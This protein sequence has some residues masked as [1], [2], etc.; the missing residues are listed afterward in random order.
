MLPMR[1]TVTE[2]PMKKILIVDDEKLMLFSLTAMFKDIDC[3]VMTATTG[4]EALQA[5]NRNRFD[6]C[7]LDIHLPDM[8]GLD[9]MRDLRACSRGTRIIMMTGGEVT[10]SMLDSVRSHADLFLSKPFDLF[11]IKALVAPMLANGRPIYSEQRA[12]GDLDS[13]ILWVAE[14]ARK[15]PRK[16]A[17][18]HLAYLTIPS[19]PAI[20]ADVRLGR[21]F[22]I[23]ES[24]LGLVTECF[25]ETGSVL[26]F[27]HDAAWRTGIVR[28]TMSTGVDNEYRTGVLLTAAETTIMQA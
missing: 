14:D 10:G 11:Q 27:M 4:Q 22:D 2:G 17:N 1:R 9:I 15:Q 3:D 6:L 23:S 24:G 13:G 26:K 20:R 21:V 8:N 28:W 12:S 5:I 16:P 19:S 7:F 25:H 18:K